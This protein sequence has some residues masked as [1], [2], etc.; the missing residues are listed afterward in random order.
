MVVLKNCL[1]KKKKKSFEELM[2]FIEFLFLIQVHHFLTFLLYP[3]PS[4]SKFGL[5]YE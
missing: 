5:E 4:A 3:I 1:S 2:D